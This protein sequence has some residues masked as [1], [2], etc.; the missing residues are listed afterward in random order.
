MD[1][2]L[3][4]GYK[5]MGIDIINKNK[6]K[7]PGMF[8]MEATL[9]FPLIFFI[10]FGFLYLSV[11]LYQNA[12]MT[13]ESLRAMNRAGAYYQY[14]EDENPKAFNESI[15]AKDLITVEDLKN[16]NKFRSIF[17]FL[18][19]E[20]CVFLGSTPKKRVESATKYVKARQMNL[21][22]D[23][24]AKSKENNGAKVAQVE[25]DDHLFF[26]DALRVDITKSYIN[27]LKKQVDRGLGLFM[28][29][30]AESKVVLTSVINKQSEFVRDVDA[31]LELA[32]IYV[33]WSDDDLA[34]IEENDESDNGSGTSSGSSEFGGG[35]SS[36]GGASR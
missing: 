11:I 34:D 32:N 2:I 12:V 23:L 24:F 16:R 28:D 7:H 8:T 22:F 1:S 20:L 27:P 33:N 29:E 35:S 14:L 18:G 21:G 31:I 17:D 15:V 5:K 9:I 26:G 6:Y 4:L 10:L 13:A 3:S 19:N 36:G 30:F 25:R